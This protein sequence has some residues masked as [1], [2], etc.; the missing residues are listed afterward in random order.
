MTL[1]DFQTLTIAWGV[2]RGFYDKENGA[3]V[4]KQF[5]KL[6]EEK[7]EMAGNIARGRCVKDDIGDMLVVLTGIAKLSGTNL[8]ECWEVAYNDIKD[9]KGK[10][11]N[12]IYVKESDLK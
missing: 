12:G 9:R 5:I 2:D 10:F 6:S 8:N 11:V 7:G 1:D 3:T 4:E